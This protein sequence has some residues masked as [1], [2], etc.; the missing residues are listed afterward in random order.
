MSALIAALGGRG[1]TPRR[2]PGCSKSSPATRAES[3]LDDE[4]VEVCFVTGTLVVEL[5]RGL[6]AVNEI[7]T[8]TAPPCSI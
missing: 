8:P 3:A 7:G 5:G 6:S 1:P 2:S 4:E